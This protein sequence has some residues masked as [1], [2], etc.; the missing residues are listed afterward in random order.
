MKELTSEQKKVR[1]NRKRRSLIN[2]GLYASGCMI[3]A[4]A[5]GINTGYISPSLLVIAG[6]L[7]CAGL[8]RVVTQGV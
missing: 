6:S 4:I 7:L 2:W 3:L 1:A 5:V 8:L